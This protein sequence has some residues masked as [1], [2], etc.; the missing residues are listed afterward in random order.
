MDQYLVQAKD[1]FSKICPEEEF[2]ALVPH[3]EDII[4]VCLLLSLQLLFEFLYSL[5]LLLQNIY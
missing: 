4:Y 3:P 1:I 5:T 2:M